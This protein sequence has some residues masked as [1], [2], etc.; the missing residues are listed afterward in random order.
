MSV[1]F[2]ITIKQT[3]EDGNSEAEKMP[4]LEFLTKVHSVSFSEP[5]SVNHDYLAKQGQKIKATADKEPFTI[6][7]VK[8]SKDESLKDIEIKI[9]ALKN[10]ITVKVLDGLKVNGLDEMVFSGVREKASFEYDPDTESW[11]LW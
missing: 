2:F 6:S 5:V 3:A 1:E 11:N 10:N 7:L 4:L 8:P 9:N